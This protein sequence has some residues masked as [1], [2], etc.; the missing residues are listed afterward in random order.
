MPERK[1]LIVRADQERALEFLFPFFADLDQTVT[2]FNS[3]ACFKHLL[4]SEQSVL[5]Q[6]DFKKLSSKKLNSEIEQSHF[7]SQKLL[8]IIF[9]ATTQFNLDY[10]LMLAGT[11][12][13]GQL[14]ILLLPTSFN[15]F[16]DES[17]LRWNQSD[18]AKKTPYFIQHLQ[19]V[20]FQ[21]QQHFKSHQIAHYHLPADQLQIQ[22]FIVNAI[23]MQP[24]SVSDKIA[25]IPKI[26]LDFLAQTQKKQLLIIGKRGRGKSTLAGRLSLS[27]KAWLTAPSKQ[28]ASSFLKVN[29]TIQFFAPDKLAQY[30]TDDFVLKSDL[31]SVLFIDEVGAIPL[32]LTKLFLE[33]QFKVVMT[34]T[35]EGYEGT[36]QAILQKLKCAYKIEEITLDIGYRFKNQDPIEFFT[37]ALTLNE[38]YADVLN[39]QKNTLLQ[40]ENVDKSIFYTSVSRAQMIQNGIINYWQ[41]LKQAHYKTD[42]SDLRRLFDGD[43]LSFYQAYSDKLI[44]LLMCVEEGGLANELI[45]Q[46]ING[47]RRPKGNLF[48]Q[49]LATHAL[50]DEAAQF[51]SKRIHRLSVIQSSRRSG[52]ATRLIK[53]LVEDSKNNLLNLY[54]FISVSFSYDP[55]LLAFWLSVGFKVVHI[56]TH[57]ETATGEQ[58]IMMM[59]A[60]TDKAQQMASKLE[61]RLI[62]NAFYFASFSQIHAQFLQQTARLLQDSFDPNL[63]KENT[64][65]LE[66]LKWLTRFATTQLVYSAILPLLFRLSEFIKAH[67]VYFKESKTEYLTQWRLLSHPFAFK[68]LKKNDLTTYSKKSFIAGLRHEVADLISIFKRDEQVLKM[69]R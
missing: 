68:E 67:P 59:F 10:F 44:A 35:T 52:I 50:C 55:H 37:E 57:K 28:A 13:A 36:G 51:R 5:K 54:D 46:I 38:T 16:I 48:V 21:M 12:K 49:S 60:L 2:L 9:E 6:P 43:G 11:L 30:L 34:T 24:L 18:Q 41:L 7:S 62:K 53:K 45:E 1:L 47:I 40:N 20:I 32:A 65:T 14:L 17:S 3:D 23:Q 64:L 25:H 29:P 56:G 8:T 15:D 26:C 69:L 63:F 66:D 39:F 58:A 33:Q 61:Q 22:S 31:P 42:L 19:Q 4:G 27:E